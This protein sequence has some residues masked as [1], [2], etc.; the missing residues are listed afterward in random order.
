MEDAVRTA[1]ILAA[2]L[3]GAVAAA[4]AAAVAG[5]AGSGQSGARI[6]DAVVVSAYCVVGA[7]VLA[8]RPGH[9]VG[10]LLVGGGVLWG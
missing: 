4:A 1:G 3:T 5:V 8:A 9:R 2:S 6:A 7:V 10:R